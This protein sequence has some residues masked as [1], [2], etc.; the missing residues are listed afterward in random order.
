MLVHYSGLDTFT[1]F[2]I[3]NL[4]SHSLAASCCTGSVRA[5]LTRSRRFC[6]RLLATIKFGLSSSSTTR[7]MP[8]VSANCCSWPSSWGRREAAPRLH[9][10][11][12][13]RGR[14]PR[15]LLVLMRSTPLHSSVPAA[16]ERFVA[17]VLLQ[18]PCSG[19]LAHAEVPRFPRGDLPIGLVRLEDGRDTVRPEPRHQERLLLD[20]H[21]AVGVRCDS[22]ARVAASR[23]G[24]GA[25]YE[26]AYYVR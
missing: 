20:L 17:A 18:L 25:R 24:V 15:E 3:V 16:R 6:R 21:H 4:T 5:R 22:R 11:H 10:R 19:V 23:H 12:G 1:G 9:P 13:G 26:W 8:T 14:H 2:S 7:S